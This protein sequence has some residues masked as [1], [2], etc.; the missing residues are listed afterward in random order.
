MKT[1][2][3]TLVAASLFTLA[4]GS[5]VLTL[6]SEA[7]QL[8]GGS[9]SLTE[10]INSGYGNFSVTM[11]LDAQAFQSAIL[12]GDVSGTI[13]SAN[14]NKIGLG[15]NYTPSA[16]LYGSWQST[17]YTRAIN[18]VN[19]SAVNLSSGLGQLFTDNTYESIAITYQ[20]T[21]T[22]TWTYLTL[23]D[24]EGT[25]STYGGNE[26]GLKANGFGALTSF[27][28]GEDYVKYLVVDDQTLS[29]TASQE[30][31]LSAIAAAAVPEP[32]TASLSLIGLAALMMR[33]RRA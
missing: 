30:A 33:R 6:D 8:A 21:S 16:G 18:P 15:L 26:S 5:P 27:T 31:N 11:A 1:A 22:G 3:I 4:Y 7:L 2:F 32:A 28:Y 13:F 12:A 19:N 23:V 29:A 14:N 24:S 17:N 25:A 20:I 9:Y 10:G